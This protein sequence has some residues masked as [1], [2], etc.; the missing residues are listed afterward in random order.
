MYAVGRAHTFTHTHTLSKVITKTFDQ[1]DPQPAAWRHAH[2]IK[3]VLEREQIVCTLKVK[4]M[5]AV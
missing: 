4:V 1:F 2:V 5:S 3:Q